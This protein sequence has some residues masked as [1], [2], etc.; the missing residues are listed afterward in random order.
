MPSQSA[1]VLTSEGG[2]AAPCVTLRLAPPL[3]AVSQPLTL[4]ANFRLHRLSCAHQS[5]QRRVDNPQV[6]DVMCTYVCD[7]CSHAAALAPAGLTCADAG[8]GLMCTNMSVLP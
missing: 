7:A 3:A 8:S 5:R 4:A 1:A 6:C 2:A